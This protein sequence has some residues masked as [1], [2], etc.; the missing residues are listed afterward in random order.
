MSPERM[1]RFSR[2]CAFSIAWMSFAVTSIPA[3]IAVPRPTSACASSSTALVMSGG[4]FSM[5]SLSSG[6]SGVGFTSLCG[7]PP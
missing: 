2:P 6:E 1:P 3:G 5:P 4:I 7:R